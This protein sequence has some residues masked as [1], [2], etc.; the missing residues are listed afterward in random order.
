VKNIFMCW[1][2]LFLFLQ[3]PVA[4]ARVETVLLQHADVSDVTFQAALQARS[5]KPGVFSYA[6]Y[7]AQRG[8]DESLGERLK[9][10]FLEAQKAF[11]KSEEV[12]VK[13]K[14]SNVTSY[15][16][17]TDWPRAYREIIQTAFLRLS[18]VESDTQKSEVYLNEAAQYDPSF[19]PDEKIFPPPLLRQFE[20]V[21]RNLKTVRLPGSLF[22]NFDKVLI[23]GVAFTPKNGARLVP[24]GLKRVTLYSS[25]Y[26]TLTRTMESS[27]LELW[28]PEAEPL[29][30]GS[31]SSMKAQVD[32]EEQKNVQFE[33]VR[34][35]RCLTDTLSAGRAPWTAITSEGEPQTQNVSNKRGRLITWGA[36]LVGLAFLA[37]SF[38]KTSSSEGGTGTHREGF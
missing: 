33:V 18:Q 29:V 7:A 2:S 3:S 11:L 23:N 27:D 24:T 1:M 37:R 12:S 38:E 21:Q 15:A 10:D 6:D 19:K 32:N 20:E 36:V 25:K 26:K 30:R 8:F 22:Q 13:S 14:W 4:W 17:K 31:C 9:N 5:S 28:L 34:P 35:D 16:Y